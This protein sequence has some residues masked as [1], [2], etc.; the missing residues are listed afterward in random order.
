MAYRPHGHAYANPSS[1]SAWGRCDRCGFIYNHK[2]LRFQF[3]YRGP[4]L[5]NL[6]FLVCEKCYDKPQAQ[7]KPI[8]VSQDPV[9]IINARPDSYDMYN[10]NNLAE[11][12]FTINTATGIPVP[13]NVDLITEDGQNI[14]TQPIG[15][16]A[17]LDPNA[18]MPLINQ[19]VYDVLL[20]VISI[21]ANGSTTITV[22]TSSA[23]SLSTGDQISITGTTDNAAM[24][25]YTVTVLSAVAF[26]YQANSVIPYGGLLGSNTRIVTA[27]VGIPPQYTQIVQ[28]GA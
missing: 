12:G 16:P 9:P 17:D 25:M 10:T 1:P 11:P 3:D 7:L 27:S 28:T 4:Q 15:K 19:T 2:T 13:N 23:N 22:T 21:T 26:T 20:P 18:L 14:T 24:G 5:Q 6:R 8:M